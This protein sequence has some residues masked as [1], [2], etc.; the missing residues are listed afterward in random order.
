M[1]I[2]PTAFV[3]VMEETLLIFDSLH[4][5]V[6]VNLRSINVDDRKRRKDFYFH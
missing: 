5:T 2:Q 3:T 4:L 1:S 6:F